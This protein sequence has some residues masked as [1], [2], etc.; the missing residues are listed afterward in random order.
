MNRIVVSFFTQ[1]SKNQ[2]M[3]SSRAYLGSLRRTRCPAGTIVV[4]CDLTEKEAW[5]VCT[6][7]DWNGTTSPCREH[8]LLDDD[9]YSG[10]LA[11]YNKYDI[12]I[13]TLRVLKNPVKFEEIRTLVGGTENKAGNMWRGFH[14]SFL[15]PFGG[16]ALSIQRYSLWASSLV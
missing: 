7:K 2:F 1:Q 3:N 5:G 14:S 8:H 9:I 10:G 16:D 15:P 13:D 12:C 11:K 4:L 6:L